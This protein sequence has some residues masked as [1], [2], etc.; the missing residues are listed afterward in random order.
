M[1]GGRKKEGGSSSSR[2][3]SVISLFC[4]FSSSRTEREERKVRTTYH[5]EASRALLKN[6]EIK[7]R[8]E[9][10]S[11]AFL[12]REISALVSRAGR[13]RGI[14]SGHS[15]VAAAS[16]R[17]D[18]PEGEADNGGENDDREC[19]LFLTHAATLTHLLK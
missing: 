5:L 6:H 9:I 17:L 19:C 14:L 16:E 3:V 15:A 12:H 1:V 18:S 10:E 11:R 7:R 2:K 8:H 4:R 13:A